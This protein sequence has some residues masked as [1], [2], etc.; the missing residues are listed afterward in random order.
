VIVKISEPDKVR[1]AATHF[2]HRVL[3]FP[4]AASDPV[5]K[6][7]AVGQT[8]SPWLLFL[9]DSVEAIDPDWLTIIAEHVQ[10]LEIG[11]VGPRLVDL[12]GTIAHDYRARR[13]CSWVEWNCAIGI[14]IA[15]NSV[16]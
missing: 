3:R 6:N 12:S 14:F 4:H 16:A 7:Y 15:R 13:H 2:P 10:R 11:A 5:S 9:D 1:E 8:D